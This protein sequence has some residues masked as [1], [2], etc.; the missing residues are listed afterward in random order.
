MRWNF[1][2]KGDETTLNSVVENAPGHEWQVNVALRPYLGRYAL[3]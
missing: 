1:V 2:L 3:N